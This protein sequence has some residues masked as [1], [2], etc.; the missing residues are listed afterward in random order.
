MSQFESELTQPGNINDV[1]FY[2]SGQKTYNQG[3]GFKAGSSIADLLAGLKGSPL[4]SMF[5]GGGAGGGNTALGTNSDA[6]KKLL[7]M[8]NQS[9]GDWWSQVGGQM[10]GEFG[11]PIGLLK[12]IATASNPSGMPVM[13]AD[14]LAA[15][16]LRT[17]ES[18]ARDLRQ[19]LSAAGGAGGNR[20]G[21]GDLASILPGQQ[22]IGQGGNIRTQASLGAAEQERERAGINANMKMGALN[23]WTGAVGQKSAIKAGA[24]QGYT[25]L[26][27]NA[28]EAAMQALIQLLGID[29]SQAAK[30]G[31]T[32]GP[33][34]TTTSIS[35]PLGA[36]LAM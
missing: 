5:S 12:S 17:A 18:G 26:Q 25:Q 11:E 28:V 6:Y 2:G 27:Q 21:I 23:A 1:N 3:Q 9:F 4:G 16:G 20:S 24:L 22:L 35:A 8:G 19:Q 33:G 13:S 34:G 7:G 29:A 36:G 32:M 10:E 15:P 31:I 14:L 30:L